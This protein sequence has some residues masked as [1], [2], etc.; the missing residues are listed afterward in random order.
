MHS[1]KRLIT[2]FLIICMLPAV[3]MV[4]IPSK[5]AANEIL[6]SSPKMGINVLSQV[7]D[8]VNDHFAY[9]QEFVT[10]WARLNAA[11]FKTSV[12]DQVVLGNCGELY[13]SE[14][15]GR[16]LSAEQLDLAAYNISLIQK[17]MENAGKSFI[18]TIA[19]DKS[20]LHGE[21]LPAN[22]T[23][24]SMG[25]EIK[26]YLE[27]YGVNYV[28][29]FD[30]AIP[31]FRTDSHWTSYGAALACDKLIGTTYA[32]RTFN[33]PSQHKGDLYE[34]LYPAGKMTED[35]YLCELS[36]TLKGNDNK[37]NAIKI[38]TTG[39]GSG[40]LFCFRDS[41]GVSLYP[42]LAEAYESATFSRST[43]YTVDKCGDSDVVI[44][45]IVER[46]LDKFL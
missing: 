19:P 1:S 3:M 24:V 36:Y 31:Y 5:A 45:E 16:E 43:E 32:K 37:G 12:E 34:M 25:R 44:L 39:E 42:Y 27:K 30:E 7:S 29:L 21:N 20:N 11:L 8:W 18:F 4:F 22:L 33:I 13:Y 2:I 35:N 41:F 38:E 28:D 23:N 17:E 46:N 10:A 40:S 6:A 15:F 14:D 9:R 26:P